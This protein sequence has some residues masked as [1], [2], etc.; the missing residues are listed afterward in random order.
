MRLRTGFHGLLRG[1]NAAVNPK[2][3][4][5]IPAWGA[6][7]SRSAEQAIHP[8]E[9]THS[10]LARNTLQVHVAAHSA[11]H[12]PDI[13]DRGSP[14]EKARVTGPATPGPQ[15]SHSHEVVLDTS[16]PGPSGTVAVT[17]R[18]KQIFFT[19]GKSSEKNT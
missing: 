10:M 8:G 18:T 1:Y 11:M 17:D 2:R 19:P 7:V 15:S 13:S 3:E 6:T 12:V 9:H 16:S 5:A 4:K 14:G